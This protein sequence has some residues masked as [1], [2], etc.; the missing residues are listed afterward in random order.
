MRRSPFVGTKE[1]IFNEATGLPLEGVKTFL[2]D[3]KTQAAFL[4]NQ[5][6][7]AK[8]AQGAQR[9]IDHSDLVWL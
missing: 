9:F 1:A 2:G 4:D 6:H 7:L 3:Y 8:L 5:A